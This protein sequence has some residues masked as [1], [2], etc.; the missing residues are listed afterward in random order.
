MGTWSS[1][2]GK[3]AKKDPDHGKWLK[4]IKRWLC[5][6]GLYQNNQCACSCKGRSAAYND[7][8]KSDEG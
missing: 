5:K 7:C 2:I 4:K 6:A 3:F 1:G 8:S